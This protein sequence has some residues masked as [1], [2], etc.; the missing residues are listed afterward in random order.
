MTITSMP[1]SMDTHGPSITME[2][3]K[4]CGCLHFA[5]CLARRDVSITELEIR[6]ACFGGGARDADGN[7]GFDVTASA[8]N[9]FNSTDS[10]DNPL[11]C[12]FYFSRE[13]R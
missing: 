7:V 4:T 13:D 9:A 2:S 10:E 6:Q 8:S 12:Y 3:E 1:P 11:Y 5:D